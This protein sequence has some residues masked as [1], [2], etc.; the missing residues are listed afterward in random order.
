MALQSIDRSG[1]AW[2]TSL[3]GG[4]S[5][6]FCD[7]A[8]GSLREM[9]DAAVAFGY[10]TFGVSE[11]VPRRAERFLYSEEVAMGWTLEKCI[12]DFERY[13]QSLNTLAEE[14]DDRI[15]IMRGFEC[16]VV[17]TESYVEIMTDYR[18]RTRPDGK[19]VFDYFV[20][21]VHYVDEMQ[22][23][24]KPEKFVEAVRTI[25]SLEALAVRYYDTIGEM[26]ER[27]HP[28]VVGH[29]D[30][31]RRN[32]GAAGMQIDEIESPIVQDAARRNLE[33]VRKH[34]AILDL[35][36]AG[37][38]KGL[39]LPYPAPW[40]V[41]M[42]AEME[43]PFCFGDDSHRTGDVGAGLEEARKYLLQ[44]GVNQIT[45]ITREGDFASGRVVRRSV[46]LDE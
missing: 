13:Q 32:V 19:P 38:R 11:H 36:T 17:P 39:G 20:G 12:D 31:V 22:I 26:V 1:A 46:A 10:H 7:H 18:G 40:L 33:I 29:Y 21:S 27:L 44:H 3:H 5:G 8:Y 30:L 16:E 25:G 4:H 34:H 43:I 35:N 24:G 6:E 2:K 41:R 45:T 15:I 9:L 42:A 23:D 14:Y 37:W 28:D